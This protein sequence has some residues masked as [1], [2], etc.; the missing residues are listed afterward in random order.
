MKKIFLILLL[1]S[2]VFAQDLGFPSQKLPPTIRCGDNFFACLAFFFE[3]I[4]K[5]ILVLAL[6]LSTIF[7]AWAG[8]LYITKGGGEEIKKIHQMLVWAAIGLIVAL[9]SF[10]FVKY[11]EGALSRIGQPEV[12]SGPLEPPPRQRRWLLPYLFNFVYAQIQEPTTPE[13]ISCGPVKLPSVFAKQTLS[14]DVWK[15]CLLYYVQRILSLL[16][17]LALMLGA[18]FLSWAGILYITQPAKSSEIHKRL[19]YGVLGIVLAI[20]SFTIVKIID[21]FFTRL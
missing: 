18:I 19:I 17:V 4:L 16:Y 5:V 3:K 9:L 8:I 14:Q 1:I 7:I 11:L 21:L 20:F 12:P 2:F 13:T 10:A 15:I 6:A